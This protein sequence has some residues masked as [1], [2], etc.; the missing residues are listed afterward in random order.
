[1]DKLG[2]NF[3]YCVDTVHKMLGAKGIPINIPIGF[4]ENF[5]GIV[6]LVEMKAVVWKSEVSKGVLL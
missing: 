6:D 1:M 4:E 5:K 2:A 3:Y